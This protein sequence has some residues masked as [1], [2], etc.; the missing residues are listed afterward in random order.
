MATVNPQTFF[1]FA[2]D[3]H[4]LLEELYGSRD[5]ISESA[6]LGLIERHSDAASPGSRYVLDRLQELGFIDH[7]PHA[8]AQYEMTRPFAELMASLLREFQMTSVE[9]IRSYFSAM[10]NLAAE[11]RESVENLNG[12]LLAPALGDATVQVEKVR[13]N[14]RRNRDGVI[15]RAIRVKANREHLP[16]RRRY[17]I[18]NRLWTRYIV[19]LRDMIDTQK[20]M[21][22]SLDRLEE[23]L[24]DAEI[25]FQ[26]DG[27][28]A[29]ATAVGRAR[30][31]R[32]RRD[33]VNDFRES[34]REIA[35]LYEELRRENA[36]ARG[37]ASALERID[38]EGLARLEIGPQMA[39]CNWQA[40]GLFSDA[41]LH[42]Y[43][44][45]LA[46]YEPARPDPLLPAVNNS[47]FTHISFD[48]FD[49][50]VN[51]AG[52]IDD[53]LSWL[54]DVYPKVSLNMILRFYNRLHSGIYGKTE[55]A[56]DEAEYLIS[57]TILIAHPMRLEVKHEPK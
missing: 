45:T 26:A 33:V 21:D 56:G 23:A 19:P 15:S 37:A 38:R 55:F 35:P 10:D 57:D 25:C 51:A 50:R 52:V 11:I 40:Q 2:A 54:A 44:L 4:G 42:A 5:G 53:A 7:A 14:S 20:A 49:V 34:V 43:F 1:R 24:V 39:V 12:E 6:L 3:H 18:I 27:A 31:R 22:A 17:V 41:A 29:P 28:L 16:P 8:T 9:V 36:L 46:N 13:Q 30:V 48:D 47:S 32:L